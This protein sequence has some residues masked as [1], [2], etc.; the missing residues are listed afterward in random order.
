MGVFNQARVLWRLLQPYASPRF[1]LELLL[2]PI[3]LI[4]ITLH[5][6]TNIPFLLLGSSISP[7]IATFAAFD[8]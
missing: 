8:F 5:L 1:F 7:Q 2:Q 6:Y 4:Q 3:L